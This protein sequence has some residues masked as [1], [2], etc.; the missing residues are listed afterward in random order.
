MAINFLITFLF[1]F[2]ILSLPSVSALD[3]NFSSPDEVEQNESFQV[4]ISAETSLIWDVKIYINDAQNA[5]EY[6]ETLVGE[7]WKNPYRFLD[8]VFP[9][10]NLF[11][12]RA[13]Q[14]G[15]FNICA[16]LR[17]SSTYT[18]C[19]NITIIENS[20]PPDEEPEEQTPENTTQN[21]SQTAETDDNNSD[22]EDEENSTGIV[23]KS[24]VQSVKSSA[25]STQTS[26][27]ED[28]EV[29]YLNKKPASDSI[30]GSSISSFMT[31][32]EKVRLWMAYG[33]AGFCVLILLFVALRKL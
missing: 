8:S 3:F 23:N 25:S 20:S 24:S 22:L 11:T 26:S 17:D 18:K 2:I 7:E 5:G 29:I 12:I 31:R 19:N 33:F 21:D 28:N 1:S 13:L 4:S 9:S 6:S 15:Y 27:Q 14:L 10:Q 16:S 30:S 32:E